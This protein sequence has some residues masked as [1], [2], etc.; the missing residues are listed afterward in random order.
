MGIQ[1]LSFI[2]FN[3]AAPKGVCIFTFLDIV[4]ILNEMNFGIIGTTV[5]ERYKPLDKSMH[6]STKMLH[7]I[8]LSFSVSN[9]S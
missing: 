7:T 5:F 9:L 8:Q 4:C 6:L 1:N 2:L 3:K